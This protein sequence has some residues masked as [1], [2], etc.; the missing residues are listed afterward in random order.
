MGEVYATEQLNVSRVA[1]DVKRKLVADANASGSSINDLVVGILARKFGVEF[2]GTGRRSP[3]AELR[4]G[5]GALVLR[6]PPELYDE[7]D[8]AV[9]LQ[10]R[11]S[12]SKVAVVDAALRE[13]YG[14]K[15]AA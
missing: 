5:A 8:A 6:M 13:H 15:A 3:G 12:R 14:L 10:P 2:T 9:R 7:I 11:G 4:P 1:P